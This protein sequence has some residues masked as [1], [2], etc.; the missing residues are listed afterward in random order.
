[1]TRHMCSEYKLAGINVCFVFHLWARAGPSAVT[2]DIYIFFIVGVCAC[3]DTLK[4]I[5]SLTDSRLYKC[6]HLS[7][8]GTKVSLT[9]FAC[10]TWGE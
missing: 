3:V 1:M 5:T 6:G 10:M 2:Q 7:A 9:L 8:W 4:H